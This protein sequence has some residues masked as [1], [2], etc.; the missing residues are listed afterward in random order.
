M[1]DDAILDF[2]PLFVIPYKEGR[3][4]SSISCACLSKASETYWG[5]TKLFFSNSDVFNCTLVH[6]YELLDSKR[7]FMKAMKGKLLVII[8]Q[9]SCF[10]VTARVKVR[11]A[12]FA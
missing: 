4:Q 8:I 9:S 7:S 1:P 12:L 6:V 5:E 11:N 2:I 10:V 3:S